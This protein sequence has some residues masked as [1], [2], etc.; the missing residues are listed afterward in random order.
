MEPIIETLKKGTEELS[1]IASGMGDLESILI[2]M[3]GATLLLF[4]RR[5]YWGVIAAAGF[6]AGS[7][8]GHEV[9]PP[10]PKWL[11]IA[12]PVLVGIVAALLSIYL[13][14]LALRL[15]GMIAGGFLGYTIAAALIAKPW[16]LLGLIL[17]CVIGFWSVM[18]LFD[19]ALIMLSSLSGTALIVQRV[20]LEKEPQLI[21][22]AVL[23]FIGIAI[24]GAMQKKAPAAKKQPSPA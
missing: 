2:M 8:I 24:Q 7:Y 19:W 5:L 18:I 1:R 20:P 12:A 11:I 23:L 16:P 9:F 17:G 3:A 4:G 22:A 21:L 13:Q 6:A 14:K 10:E 15:A